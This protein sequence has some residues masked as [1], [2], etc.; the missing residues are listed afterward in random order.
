MFD[1]IELR[2]SNFAPPETAAYAALPGLLLLRRSYLITIP[3]HGHRHG[4]QIEVL[5][6]STILSPVCVTDPPPF[7]G[8]APANLGSAGPSGLTP[9]LDRNFVAKKRHTGGEVSM[10]SPESV[11]CLVKG[12]WLENPTRLAATNEFSRHRLLYR[13]RRVGQYRNSAG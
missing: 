11:A 4:H 5:V 6:T 10:K 13:R 12:W 7:R 2:W 8:D 9:D 1:G 3:I